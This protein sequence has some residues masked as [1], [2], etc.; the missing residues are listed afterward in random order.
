MSNQ[1]PEAGPAG[2]SSS[3]ADRQL[4]AWIFDI[5]RYSINDGPGIRTTV[6]FK[7]CPLRCLWCDN[8]ESQSQWPQ[9][10]YF[11]SL[12]SRCHRCISVCPNE[13]I[14]AGPD[15]SVITDRSRC[16]ACGA[17]TV[18]CPNEARVITGKL[19]TVNEVMDVVKQDSLFYRNS[20]GGVTA[21][22]GEALVH[23][24][25]LFELFKRCRQNG[26]HTA[27]DTTGYVKW[28][29]LAR[30]LE[31]TD[32][33]LMDIKQIDSGRHREIT[34]VDNSRILEN[35][36]KIAGSG[37]PIWIRFPL[38]PGCTDDAANIR[39]TGEF[40]L[41]LGLNTLDILPYHQLGTGKYKRLDMEYRLPQA[42]PYSEDQIEEMKSRLESMGLEVRIA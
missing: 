40:V 35:A 24:D 17:C 39:A 23:D 2:D 18:V 33:V 14:S 21:S 3:E 28:E 10:F 15:D 8:P 26:I 6:F 9:L 5:Q 34:G 42:R 31:E 38:I 7:G 30:I 13:A 32:L 20:G 19:M 41:S 11:E 22:G 37:K 25:F 16:K 1:K 12:C 36:R 29:A 4:K 27:L